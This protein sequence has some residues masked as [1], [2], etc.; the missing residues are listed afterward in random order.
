MTR[1]RL[2]NVMK[3]LPVVQFLAAVLGGI[4]AA[5]AAHVVNAERVENRLQG[6]EVHNREQDDSIAATKL[7]AD[8]DREVLIRIDEN[9]KMLIK[10]DDNAKS[11]R[12]SR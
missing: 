7:Q 9:V 3:F 11:Q 5:Y 8:K 10:T 2:S 6:L 4:G 1:D 12:G